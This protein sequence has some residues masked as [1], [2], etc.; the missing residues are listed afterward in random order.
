MW[1]NCQINDT[2]I[3]CV[4]RPFALSVLFGY[5]CHQSGNWGTTR[6]QRK[7]WFLEVRQQYICRFGCLLAN[8]CTRCPYTSRQHQAADFVSSLH[9]NRC[10]F[11]HAWEVPTM[12]CKKWQR[13][14]FL[15]KANADVLLRTVIFSCCRNRSQ[16]EPCVGSCVSLH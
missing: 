4:L 7:L 13:G 5:L 6:I 11:Y 15:K 16:R 8:T 1:P 12:H 14:T 2:E 10:Q 3:I 9:G